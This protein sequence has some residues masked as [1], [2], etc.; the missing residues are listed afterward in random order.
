MVCLNFCIFFDYL[1]EISKHKGMPVFNER[2]RYR[3]IKA[4]KWVDEVGYI[5]III[6]RINYLVDD[7]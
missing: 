1:A 3:L 6:A 7:F 4:I 5:L 2:E